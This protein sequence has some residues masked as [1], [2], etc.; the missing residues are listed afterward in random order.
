[1]PK[2]RQKD[3]KKLINYPETTQSF[4]QVI[5]LPHWYAEYWEK[6]ASGMLE[7]LDLAFPIPSP[8]DSTFIN[9]IN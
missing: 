6:I 4:A 2:H 7:F 1:M 3:D 8:P 9:T 5:E